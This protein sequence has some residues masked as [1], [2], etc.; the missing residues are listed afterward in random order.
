MASAGRV[1]LF[2][3]VWLERRGLNKED[4]EEAESLELA[5]RGGGTRVKQAG[6]TVGIELWG[7]ALT[8]EDVSSG[9]GEVKVGW[10]NLQ[11]D[12]SHRNSGVFGCRLSRTSGAQTPSFRRPENIPG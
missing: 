3:R 5:M 6:G 12:S 11:V 9:K 4:A 1:V 2:R 10:T 8:G 7:W